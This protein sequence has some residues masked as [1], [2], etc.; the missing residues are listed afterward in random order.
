MFKY[1]SIVCIFMMLC[2]VFAFPVNAE[3]AMSAEIET[4][5]AIDS[6]ELVEQPISDI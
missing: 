4:A 5:D 2:L 3:E 6:A 1:K